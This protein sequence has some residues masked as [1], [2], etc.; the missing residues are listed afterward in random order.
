MGKKTL[1]KKF[2]RTIDMKNENKENL[3]KLLYKTDSCLNMMQN[4]KFIVAF[5][6]LQ[7][8]R[9]IIL[10]MIIEDVSIGEIKENVHNSE[11]N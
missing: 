8:I 3:K 2:S 6:K 4:G 1:L 5:E 9:Q 10:N 7:G 11:E